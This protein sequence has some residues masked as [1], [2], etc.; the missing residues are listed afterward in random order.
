MQSISMPWL[1]GYRDVFEHIVNLINSKPPIET[2]LGAL[3]ILAA[4]AVIVSV[5][6]QLRL[7]AMMQTALHLLSE[8]MDQD[9]LDRSKVRQRRGIDRRASLRRRLE[10]LVEWIKLFNNY[11]L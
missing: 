10:S 7:I 6:I 8:K 1:W 9:R 4:V 2:G 3:L 5:I 11:R